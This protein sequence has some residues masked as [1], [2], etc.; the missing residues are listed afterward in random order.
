[1]PSKV[2]YARSA[3]PNVGL[4]RIDRA[5]LPRPWKK[6]FAPPVAAPAPQ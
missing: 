5:P 4:V 2:K 6:P 1:M 3:T